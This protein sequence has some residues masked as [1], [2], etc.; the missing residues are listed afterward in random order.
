VST[1]VLD[2]LSP[3]DAATFVREARR[4]LR[5]GG[6]LALASLAPGRT[7]P[8]RLVTALWQAIWRL[9]PALLGGC[10]PLTLRGL[11]DPD[12]WSPR[13]DSTVTDWFLS[14]EVLVARRR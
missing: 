9:N 7:A 3:A 13:S 4:V 14:S 5:P 12:E 6:L 2:L 1:Y 10:R 11:L 8:A